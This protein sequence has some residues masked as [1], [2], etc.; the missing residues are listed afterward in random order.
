MFVWKAIRHFLKLLG[1]YCIL[2][3]PRR[4]ISICS[5]A[6][7]LMAL[8]FLVYFY[9]VQAVY[10]KNAESYER[11]LAGFD[12]N[13]LQER[14]ARAIRRDSITCRDYAH[15][16][17]T[18]EQVQGTDRAWLE[19]NMTN[20]LAGDTFGYDIVLFQ[21]A[22]GRIIFYKGVTQQIAHDI[23]EYGLIESCL[24]GKE[25][26]GL[27]LLGGRLY[28]CSAYSVLKSDHSGSPRGML[29][30]AR[31]LDNSVLEELAPSITHRLAVYTKSGRSVGLGWLGPRQN[32]APSLE[33]IFR[34]AELPRDRIVEKS[35]EGSLLY[36][37]LP[38]R[39]IRDR[40]VGV[41]IDVRSRTALV[42]NLT[43]VRQTTLLLMIVCLIAG[44]VGLAYMRQHT[45][46]LRA[47]RDELT[48]LYN[49]GYLQE[50]LKNQVNLAERYN[51][52]LSVIM[53]DVDHFKFVND[54]H[55][56]HAGDIVLKSV[57]ATLNQTL[58]S[59]DVVARYGG[60]EFVVVCP[61][62]TAAEAVAVAER[63]R[64]T[65][66]NTSI[67]LKSVRTKEHLS[68]VEIHVTISAGVASYPECGTS[69][70]ELLE[71]ADAALREAK[72]TR[73]RVVAYADVIHVEKPKRANIIDAFMRDSSI[74]AIRPLIA[75]IEARDPNTIRHSEKTAEYA[76]AI[77]REMGFSTYD[78]SLIFKAA[79]LHDVGM[80]AV[81][82]SILTKNDA[83]NE[84]EMEAVKLHPK[85]SAAILAQSPQLAQVAD[86]VLYHHENW[87]GT[88]YPTGL[89][90][91]DIPLMARVV[92]V[93]GSLDSMTSPR[94]YRSQMTLAEAKQELIAQAG[95]QFDPD[96]V[97]AA[98][99]VVD[100]VLA[101]RETAKSAA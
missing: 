83:L 59:T 65:I 16:D 2:N 84:Q 91:E 68:D 42:E 69:R 17:D 40:L 79:L 20:G 13:T 7:L 3:V 25:K 37:C 94:T 88:G 58:R 95:K 5:L 24:A 4:R 34:T 14:L 97:R 52:Q 70:Q 23:V 99:R 78:I 43:I 101:Q 6:P 49:H 30:V 86:I 54:T 92:N 48:G 47:H 82:D 56:H 90:G 45:I 63:I 62:T 11:K 80:I 61:E 12:L 18:Y 53:L 38:V 19:T 15:W 96:V 93:A 60:E 50:Y 10:T 29:L 44:V 39:D 51:R 77:A 33:R 22:D 1:S 26:A 9:S 41:L 87:D 64:A 21:A 57:A 66:E 74:S 71:A 35:V 46:A 27:V 72:R 36:S 85:V 55:G 81:P 32:W 75:A 8:P 31:L 100:A 73:N 67:M 28:V 76:V 89:K 98:C